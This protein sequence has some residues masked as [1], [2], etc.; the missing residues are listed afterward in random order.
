MK[1]IEI[2]IN[3]VAETIGVSEN[4]LYKDFKKCIDKFEQYGIT[5]EGKGKKRKFYQIQQDIV[6]NEKVA[7][8]TFEQIAYNVWY[9]DRRVDIDKL[10]HFMA[11]ILTTQTIEGH[12]S[13][14]SLEEIAK[15]IDIDR[16]TLRKYK[17]RL[18]AYDVVVPHGLSK[19][20]TYASLLETEYKSKVSKLIPNRNNQFNSM[21]QE[22]S[23]DNFQ[24]SI[25]LVDGDIIKQEAKNKVV[26]DNEIFDS[27]IRACKTVAN[28]KNLRLKY[29][30]DRVKDMIEQDKKE[31]RVTEAD[32]YIAFQDF[33]RELGIDKLYQVV[34][35]EY[36]SRT[37]KDTL[38][39]DIIVKAFRY[40]FSD[41]KLHE[42]LKKYDMEYI[43]MDTS[44]LHE[45]GLKE[46]IPF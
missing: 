3:E 20:V 2:N 42:K 35:T 32:K 27:Y 34:K 18:G 1:T 16:E 28:T 7:Y 37:M 15:V 24:Y 44:E 45:E 5:Y 38:L 36:T 22:P 17:Q 40:K 12:T 4:T 46:A 13:I 8:D 9:F 19:V 10:L 26:V 43:Q 21:D 30:Y 25:E 14:L 31:L 6:S 41:S 39:L 29:E 11:I 33:K 23:L